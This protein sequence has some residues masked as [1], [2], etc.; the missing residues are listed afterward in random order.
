M[1]ERKSL[2]MELAEVIDRHVP[3]RKADTEDCTPVHPSGWLRWLGKHLMPNLGSVVLV[4]VLLS[5]FPGLAAPNQAPTA[6]SISTIPYQGRLADA[7]GTPVTGMQNMEFRI[8]DVPTSGTPLWEEFWTG[9]NSVSVSD[10]L[11][12]VLL[13]SLNTDLVNVVQGHEALYLGV[14]VGTDSEMAPRVQL[15]SVPF[16]MQALTVPDDSV[17]T[18]KIADGAV[19]TAKLGADVSFVPPDGSITTVKLADD[20]V[21]AAKI[22]SGAV[23]SSEVADNSLTASDL[24][25]GSVGSSEVT[26][27][28]L[29]AADLAADSVGSSEIVNGAVTQAK[30]P[31]APLT[32]WYGVDSTPDPNMKVA[33]STHVLDPAGAN[34][35]QINISAY[36]F[37]DK[38]AGICQITDT[39]LTVPYYFCAYS[40]DGSSKDV[41]HLWFYSYNGT[42]AGPSGSLRVTLLLMGK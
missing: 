31:F 26:D 28:S 1:D 9:G 16:S 35:L 36:G 17:T 13:G 38:P 40:W 11:F 2:V 5:A 30:A 37:T 21:T 6:T 41:A 24:A 3:R 20:A 32:Y 10:G 34:Y 42:S 27:N 4:L 22:A 7:A 19:T 18:A 8:Y 39:S 25:A 33:I 12:S 14:T 29:T 15:G 23:G